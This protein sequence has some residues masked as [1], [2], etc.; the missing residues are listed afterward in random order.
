MS[1]SVTINNTISMQNSY[2]QLG[3]GPI[4]PGTT[5]DSAVKT[6]QTSLFTTLNANWPKGFPPLADT[7]QHDQG[8]MGPWSDN[9]PGSAP[10]CVVQQLS[11]DFK[12]WE[13]PVDTNTINTMAAQITQEISSNGGVSGTFFGRSQIG[14]SETV[15]WGVGFATGA[16]ADGPD[17]GTEELGIIY[18]I[19]AQLDVN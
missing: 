19:T 3:L 2:D 16:I 12:S 9:I 17:G 8:I 11:Q 14:G 4:P 5:A 6:V 7:S 10:S 18:V 1:N 13:M 15:H